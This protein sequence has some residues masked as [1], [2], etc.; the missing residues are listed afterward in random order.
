MRRSWLI[1]ER[2][3]TFVRFGF[4]WAICMS[5]RAVVAE[6][7]A[8]VVPLIA[9]PAKVVERI[10]EA[11]SN[12]PSRGRDPDNFRQRQA[13]KNASQALEKLRML[14]WPDYATLKLVKIEDLNA[15]CPSRQ[16]IMVAWI[17]SAK[18]ETFSLLTE[19]NELIPLPAKRYR[20]EPFPFERFW[21]A[22]REQILKENNLDAE[23]I[24]WS[25]IH[26]QGG[27]TSRSQYDAIRLVNFV[28]LAA[29]FAK[30]KELTLLVD[31]EL[32]A[33]P[34]GNDG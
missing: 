10:E 28:Y 27:L 29:M 25:T 34:W 33:G 1:A 6:N 30:T 17:A 9:M 5:S 26:P 18:D 12:Y 31:R 20:I 8:Q 4:V 7:A 13:R 32:D 19:A 14:R 3:M 23:Q 16:I 22:E 2:F 11:I 24:T 21:K 15:V